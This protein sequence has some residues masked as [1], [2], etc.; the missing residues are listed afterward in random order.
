M[1]IKKR[2]PLSPELRYF[3][4]QHLTER[5]LQEI[6]K[7]LGLSWLTFRHLR[8]KINPF[9]VT[10]HTEPAVIPML[11]KAIENKMRWAVTVRDDLTALIAKK[12]ELKSE[13]KRADKNERHARL[14]IRKK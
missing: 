4:R 14:I 3:L 12:N 2:E 10:D 6:G 8:K 7:E 5:D 1:K 13:L 11:R 9:R